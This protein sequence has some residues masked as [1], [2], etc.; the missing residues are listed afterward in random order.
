MKEQITSVEGA[1]RVHKAAKSRI[2]SW[3]RTKGKSNVRQTIIDC[4]RHG[5]ERG[6]GSKSMH[7]E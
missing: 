7:R 1:T 3:I 4:N 6:T 5:R 2:E